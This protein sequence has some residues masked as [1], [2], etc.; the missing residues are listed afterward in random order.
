MIS[1]Q[2]EV[3]AMGGFRKRQ[4]GKRKDKGWEWER[5]GVGKRKIRGGKGKD[6]GWERE[7]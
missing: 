7:R 5:K 1:L 4:G 2:Y 3:V 6:K